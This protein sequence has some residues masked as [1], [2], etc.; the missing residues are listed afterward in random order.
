MLSESQFNQLIQE[1]YFE[2]EKV[3]R[4]IMVL[5]QIIDNFEKIDCNL[6]SLNNYSEVY[7]KHF[8]NLP[9]NRLKEIVLKLE[10]KQREVIDQEFK[11]RLKRLKGL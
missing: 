11:N 8:H 6:P 10:N 7:C 1:T 9:K 4:Q 2:Y 3:K 5:N